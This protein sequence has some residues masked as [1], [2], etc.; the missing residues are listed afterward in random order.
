MSSQDNTQR[1]GFAPPH[2]ITPGM[3]QTNRDSPPKPLARWPLALEFIV[4]TWFNVPSS[5]RTEMGR[6]GVGVQ[7]AYDQ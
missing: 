6:D 3:V 4:W 5:L 7:R 1:G 2:P